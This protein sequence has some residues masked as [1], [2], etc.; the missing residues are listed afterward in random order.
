MKG[1]GEVWG[2]RRGR[3]KGRG[4]MGGGRGKGKLGGGWIL[5]ASLAKACQLIFQLCLLSITPLSLYPLLFLPLYKLLYRL[6]ITSLSSIYPFLTLHIS[7]LPRLAA[8]IFP[9]FPLSIPTNPSLRP[10]LSTL[11]FY[12]FYQP[13]ASLESLYSIPSPLPSL[14]YLSTPSLN[15]SLSFTIPSRSS[16]STLSHLSLSTPLFLLSIP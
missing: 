3:G 12:P 7:S 16:I 15:L 9:F 8:F 4:R 5:F 11:S 1:W 6:C 10:L 14:D 13:S 2:G